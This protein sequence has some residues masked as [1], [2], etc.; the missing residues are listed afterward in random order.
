MSI[1]R[2]AVQKTNALENSVVGGSIDSSMQSATSSVDASSSVSSVT[3]GSTESASASSSSS[4]SLS[5]QRSSG[6]SESSSVSQAIQQTDSQSTSAASG[7]QSTAFAGA[8]PQTT[9]ASTIT[10]TTQNMDSNADNTQTSGVINLTSAPEQASAI[11]FINSK[12]IVK[13]GITVYN[14]TF[15]ADATAETNAINSIISDSALKPPTLPE[16]TAVADETNPTSV[17]SLAAMAASLNNQIE[18]QIE[19]DQKKVNEIAQK[20]SVDINELAL[21]GI[22][23][24]QFQVV[25]IGYNTYLTLFI[26][27]VKFYDS[28]EVYRNQTVID[29]APVLRKLNF[30]SDSKFEKMVDQQYKAE[31]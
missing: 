24:A 5:S 25:P 12:D 28:K 15:E 2:A 22:E 11:P 14:S 7:T 26:K 4:S 27:D 29:N 20:S 31:Q 21:G 16:A 18:D 3:G 13:D 9:T 23:L 1:S 10:S 30:A 17:R 6:G 8:G 19:Q